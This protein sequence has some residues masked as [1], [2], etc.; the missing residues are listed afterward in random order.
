VTQSQ[1]DA[2]EKGRASIHTQIDVPQE[3]RE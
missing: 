3:V 1:R 2:K